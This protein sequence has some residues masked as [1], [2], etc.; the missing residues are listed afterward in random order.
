MVEILEFGYARVSTHSQSVDSQTT[1]IVESC[2]NLFSITEE[3]AG[4]SSK[5]KFFELIHKIPEHSILVVCEIDRAFRN[6]AECLSVLESLSDKNCTFR[7]ILENVDSST[8]IGKGIII[9]HVAQAEKELNRIR[10]RTRRG[11]EH[12]KALGKKLGPPYR[13]T[14]EQAL[15]AKRLHEEEN[16]SIHRLGRIFNVHPTTIGRRIGKFK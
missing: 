1:P 10:Q 2:S 13:L 14:H 4:A 8:E 11:L 7:S 16:M 15:E 9:G 12:A 6:V 3:I 5:T